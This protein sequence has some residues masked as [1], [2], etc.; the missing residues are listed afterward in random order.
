MAQIELNARC[1]KLQRRLLGLPVGSLYEP[2]H[3]LVS[4]AYQQFTDN[5]ISYIAWELCTSR[6]QEVRCV[7][8]ESMNTLIVADRQGRLMQS[9]P[10]PQPDADTSSDGKLLIALQR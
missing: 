4:G 1:V 6:D 7:K 9:T 2:S 8:K 3:A 10:Q 5:S